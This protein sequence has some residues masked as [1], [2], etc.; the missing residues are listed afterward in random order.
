MRKL[1]ELLILA[2]LCAPAWATQYSTNFPANENPISENGNWL[3]GSTNGGGRWDNVQTSGGVAEDTAV[4]STGGNHSYDDATAVLNGSWAPNQTACGTVRINAGWTGRNSGTHELELRLRTTIS[5]GSITG[6]EINYSVETDGNRYAQ[7]VRWNGPGGSFSGI[8]SVLP[9]ALS[10]GDVLCA[11]MA[12]NTITA[13]R[14]GA[15]FLTATDGTFNSGAPGIGLWNNYSSADNSQFGF[16]SFTAN[17]DGSAGSG[18]SVNPPAAQG[19]LTANPIS[20]SQIALS[21]NADPNPPTAYYIARCTGTS[22]TN[23][24]W[25]S[26]LAATNF[27]DTQLSAATTYRYYVG[28]LRGSAYSQYT[29]IASA[30]TLSMTSA[31]P[32]AALSASQSSIVAGSPVTLTWSSKNATSATLAPSIG[33]VATSGSMTLS[34]SVTTTYMLTVNGSGGTAQATVTVTVM[35]AC[36]T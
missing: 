32:T 4:Q 17:D 8:A 16:S 10:N 25:L 13:T 36:T 31:S 5:A 14:N 15:T 33:G 6:Y 23:W 27:T 35:P 34:P 12:G 11:T 18:G 22:C 26:T 30:T 19:V 9:P 2:M 20:T 29:N 7:I 24:K 21:W 28:E 3:N 1:A